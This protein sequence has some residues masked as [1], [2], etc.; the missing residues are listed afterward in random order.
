MEWNAA[1]EAIREHTEEYLTS[2]R[3]VVIKGRNKNGTSRTFSCI[4]PQHT[5]KN[6]SMFYSYT[7]RRAVCRVCKRSYDIFDLIGEDYNLSSLPDQIRK[8]AELYGITIE[9]ADGKRIE[10]SWKRRKGGADTV[11]G[12]GQNTDKTGQEKDVYT[13][14]DTHT[15]KETSQAED[16][17]SYFKTCSGRISGTKY[18]ES[19]GLSAETLERHMIGYEPQF[20]TRD[21][22]TDQ[23][24]T[25]TALIIPTGRGSYTVRNTD[26]S[27]GKRNRYRNRGPAALFNKKALYSSASPVFCVEGEID[28]MSIEEAGGASVGLGSID[29]VPL[30]LKTLEERRPSQP[31]IIAF[32]NEAEP[33]KA[34]NVNKAEEELIS[35]LERLKIPY[36]RLRPYGEY[37]DANEALVGNREAFTEEIRNAARIQDQAEEEAREAY[38]STSAGAHLQKFLDGI[39]E[40]VNT[41]AIPTGFPTLDDVLDGGLYEGLIT[42][43]AISSLGKTSLVL[44]VADQVAA[45]GYDVLILSL[46]MSRYQLMSKSISRHTLQITLK[47]GWDT[48][49]AKTSRGITS[50]KRYAN[51][52]RT[53]LQLIKDATSAYSEYADR[54]YIHEG[55]GDIGVDQIR[56]LVERHILSTGGS[57]ETDEKTGE[58]RLSGGRRPLLVCDYLQIIAPYNDRATDKQNTDK[59]VLELKRISRDYKLPV[60]AISSFNRMNYKEAVSM[61]AFKESGAVEYSSDVLIG[62]QLKGAGKKEFNPTDEKKKNPRE[63]ELVVL[64]NRD[65]AV[66]DKVRFLYYPMFNYFTD[67]G[68]SD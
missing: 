61:E 64:K 26:P 63:V 53:E 58:R 18:P 65:G 30:L 21:Q 38:L 8:G 54:I 20:R 49:N 31:L 9:D 44:Q 60:I 37:K 12:T 59:A 10:E 14:T 15:H 32:D 35:G 66:G 23:Y 28:A 1:E 52:N 27:A 62:L 6:P 36:Y 13:H 46:E 56:E 43:G 42:I 25:W 24:T 11:S 48:R 39:A 57:W 33:D 41:T 7:N 67:Q 34:E 40:S 19:R 47:G 68:L 5:D 3:G 45:A 55:V 51:Y 17:L 50:G 16:Y 2:R 4:S 29:N 22:E